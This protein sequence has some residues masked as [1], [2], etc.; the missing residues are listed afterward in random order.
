MKR[1]QL[2]PVL[3]AASFC[4]GLSM[5]AASDVPVHALRVTAPGAG[6]ARTLYL[7]SDPA[8]VM[9]CLRSAVL[10]AGNGSPDYVMVRIVAPAPSPQMDGITN[11]L[12]AAG[13]YH[14]NIVIAFTNEPQGEITIYMWRYNGGPDCAFS[15][16]FFETLAGREPRDN[17]FDPTIGCAMR[18]NLSAQVANRRDL[19]RGRGTRYS[20][21]ERAAAAVSQYRSGK[22]AAQARAG[23]TANG[24]AP[25]KLNPGG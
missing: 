10:E 1:S 9:D 20:D 18:D 25:A 4:A 13:I 17:S 3:I 15:S 11:D 7:D 14:R 8:M 6:F 22:P 23:E 24:A 21:G 12:Q 2:R 5:V 19:V 16:Q